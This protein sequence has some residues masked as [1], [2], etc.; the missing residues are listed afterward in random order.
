MNWEHFA[1]ED[2]QRSKKTETIA[3]T[4]E[5]SQSW[6]CRWWSAVPNDSKTFAFLCLTSSLFG[7][8]NLKISLTNEL[9]EWIGWKKR[10]QVKQA[11]VV[12]RAVL[13][14]PIGRRC[15]EF[16]IRVKG[17]HED[18]NER[19]ME[20]IEGRKFNDLNNKK[21]TGKVYNSW[22]KTREEKVLKLTAA[23][24]SI[25]QKKCNEFF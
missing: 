17:I 19:R 1:S 5:S 13:W 22:Q 14:L 10:G 4:I 8:A 15:A 6:R 7:L 23:E 12:S 24:L 2:C 9:T 20:K 21:S 11:K 3:M 18:D 16:A 25:I